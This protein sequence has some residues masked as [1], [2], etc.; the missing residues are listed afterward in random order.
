MRYI[1]ELFDFIN[2]NKMP[3]CWA[4]TWRWL[5]TR[6]GTHISTINQQELWIVNN[7]PLK[8]KAIK[9]FHC[10]P[11]VVWDNSVFEYIVSH[12]SPSET[13]RHGSSNPPFPPAGPSLDRFIYSL[14]QKS[15]HHYQNVLP[16]RPPSS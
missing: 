16:P 2:R 5:N 4:R 9:P 12:D 1:L 6:P 7:K 10:Y 15:I 8:L 11:D 13:S 3:I 14:W